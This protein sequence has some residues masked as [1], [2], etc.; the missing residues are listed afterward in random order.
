MHHHHIKKSSSQYWDWLVGSYTNQLG[1]IETLWACAWFGIVIWVISTSPTYATFGLL[2]ALRL[3]TRAHH[4]YWTQM[5]VLFVSIALTVEAFINLDRATSFTTWQALTGLSL[6]GTILSGILI[7]LQWFNSSVASLVEGVVD[8]EKFHVSLMS[9][10]V[11]TI[12][13]FGI[14]IWIISANSSYSIPAF[15]LLLRLSGSTHTWGA[16]LQTCII[17]GALI[18]FS[19]LVNDHVTNYGVWVALIALASIG[20]AID[21]FQPMRQY[22]QLG[23]SVKLKVPKVLEVPLGKLKPQKYENY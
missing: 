19:V 14:T 6:A 23:F 8:K 15:L 22:F 13:W 7:V 16:T 4:S 12:A 9:N 5:Q 21:V 20:L 1:L 17:S 18:G 3:V 11:W 10:L 2:L